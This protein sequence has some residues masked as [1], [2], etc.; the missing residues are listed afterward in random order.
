MYLNEYHL[1]A[2]DPGGTIGW[3]YFI[4]DFQAFTAPKNKVLRYVKSWECGEFE[5]SES[6]QCAEA[7]KLTVLASRAVRFDIISEDFDL[8][9]LVG[10][11][12]LLSPVR[13]NAVIG[14]ACYKLGTELH[15]QSRT[16]RTGVTPE[17]L[18]LFG[19]RPKPP[20]RKWTKTSKGKDAF[21][22]MQHGVVWLRRTKEISRG[23]P[24]I[25]DGNRSG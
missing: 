18:E 15:L 3:A 25:T 13:I 11:K 19:F 12:Q 17:R 14:Y 22:A 6:E 24:W 20:A 7:L 16:L 2:F 10:G 9:Q 8:V 4:V 1:V 21:A 23:K 5:G